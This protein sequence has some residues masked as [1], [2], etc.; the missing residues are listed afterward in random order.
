MNQKKQLATIIC[1][2]YCLG[3]QLTTNDQCQKEPCWALQRIPRRLSIYSATKHWIISRRIIFFLGLKLKDPTKAIIIKFHRC[4]PVLLNSWIHT[5][6][7]GILHHTGNFGTVFVDQSYWQSSVAAK[8]KDGV[9]GFL[10]GG[11]T[12]FSVP[13]MFATTMGLTYIALGILH[14]STLLKDDEVEQGK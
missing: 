14:G 7:D 11:L 3:L 8:P 1:L 12:W 6:Y 10:A 9:W 4:L 5:K 13:F 2:H